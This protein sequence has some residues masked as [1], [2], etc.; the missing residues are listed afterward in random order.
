MVVFPASTSRPQS[1]G[2]MPVAC[3]RRSISR[4]RVSR[5]ASCSSR[6]RWGLF[7]T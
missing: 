5:V 6:S 3:S 4:R 7:F 2:G 1:A